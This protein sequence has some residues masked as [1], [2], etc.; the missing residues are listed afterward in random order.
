MSSNRKKIS[1]V[2]TTLTGLRFAQATA[3]NQKQSISE[4]HPISPEEWRRWVDVQG[5]ET[6][7][8]AG[9]NAA[10]ASCA[11]NDGDFANE[12]FELT[13]ADVLARSMVRSRLRS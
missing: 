8:V 13:R 5:S 3:A 11:R 2:T 1:S 9:E 7:Q 12:I 4:Q 6:I 10:A